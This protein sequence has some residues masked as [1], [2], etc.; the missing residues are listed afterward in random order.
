ML[1]ALV[2]EEEGH[3]D[4]ACGGPCK[5]CDEDR[6]ELLLSQVENSGPFH[7]VVA[8]D[9]EDEV[10]NGAAGHREVLQRNRDN[11]VVSARAGEEEK[12]KGNGKQ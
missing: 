12:E 2:D 7:R 8:V 1:I 9:G 11:R 10:A 5:E 3:G 6:E 4:G